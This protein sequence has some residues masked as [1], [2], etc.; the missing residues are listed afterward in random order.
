MRSFRS[1]MTAILAAVVAGSVIGVGAATAR[2][3]VLDLET[4]V[5]G[6]GAGGLFQMA[7]SSGVSAFDMTQ[8]EVLSG[9]IANDSVGRPTN[10]NFFSLDSLKTPFTVRI[11]EWV[12]VGTQPL[13]GT[14]SVPPGMTASLVNTLTQQKFTVTTGQ[15]TIPTGV[16]PGAKP[17][18]GGTRTI[19][20]HGT[21]TSCTATVP[22][23]RGANDRKLVIRLTATN[24]R[25]LSVTA[26]PRGSEGAY[27]LTGPHFALGRSEYIVTLDAVKANPRGSHL[28]LKFGTGR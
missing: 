13:I 9:A 3:V 14:A 21:A 20:C 22:I 26:V 7:F 18:A 8:F 27:L 16:A 17:P 25:L 24:L 23:A 19:A 1:L 10:P 12:M 2:T 5:Q 28:V 6:T 4:T 11:D 15:I